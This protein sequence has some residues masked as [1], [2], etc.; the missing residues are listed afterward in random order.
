MTISPNELKR[1]Q[2]RMTELNRQ[3]R[4]EGVLTDA[5]KAERDRIEDALAEAR[6]AGLVVSEHALLRYMERSLG[7]NLQEVTDR[8]VAD[9]MP[10][11][12]T[13]GDGKYPLSTGGQAVVR[14]NTVVTVEI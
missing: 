2:R 7:M 6:K 10:L 4:L 3:L 9:V 5:L 11:A 14:D 1:L 8:I 13:L 12:R